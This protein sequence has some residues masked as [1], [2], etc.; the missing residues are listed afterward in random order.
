VFLLRLVG[1]LV[2][3]AIGISIV[4]FLVTGDRKH[5]RFALKTLK[6]AVILAVFLLSL[7]VFER[8]VVLV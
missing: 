5:L 3:I 6:W 8:L 1:I 2:V 7:I 4:L